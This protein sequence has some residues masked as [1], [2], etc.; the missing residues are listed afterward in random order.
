MKYTI[1]LFVAD[2]PH[3]DPNITHSR[4][5][6]INSGHLIFPIDSPHHNDIKDIFCIEVFV[7]QL[8]Y[9]MTRIQRDFHMESI[10]VSYVTTDYHV[11]FKSNKETVQIKQDRASRYIVSSRS[12]RLVAHHTHIARW[13]DQGD[14][15]QFLAG[16]FLAERSL[17]I[18]VGG[19]YLLSREQL[20]V[21]AH[22]VN[23][24]AILSYY[25]E[26]YPSVFITIQA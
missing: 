20:S 16:S 9:D 11:L 14:M 6:L 13:E 7:R 12:K 21:I 2:Y 18:A 26:E 1:T 19:T 3:I 17:E 4:H 15:L 5:S 22:M 24:P 23:T 8:Q 25:N 10:P